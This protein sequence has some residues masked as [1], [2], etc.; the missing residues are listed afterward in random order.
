MREGARSIPRHGR[1][2]RRGHPKHGAYG[3]LGIEVH[4]MRARRQGVDE[5]ATRRHLLNS[6]RTSAA[7]LSRGRARAWAVAFVVRVVA[8]HQTRADRNVTTAALIERPS[9]CA[10]CGRGPYLRALLRSSPG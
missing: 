3:C 2:G 5:R 9:L 1:T 8:M 10:L 7:S 6:T 4:P